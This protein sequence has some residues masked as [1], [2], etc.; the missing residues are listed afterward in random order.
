MNEKAKKLIAELGAKRARKGKDFMG[1]EVFI[2]QYNGN[3]KIGL[4]LVVLQKGDEAR[5]STN[6]EAMDYLDVM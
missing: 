1:Y 5:I 3:P 4:P 6:K 2:P